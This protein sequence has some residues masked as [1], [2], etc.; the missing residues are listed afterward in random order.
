MSRANR[1]DR[2]NCG[3]SKKVVKREQPKA[4]SDSKRMN[5][6]NARVSRVRED[7]ER[8][9]QK[10]SANDISWYAK[11]PE[12]LKSAASIP[13]ASVLGRPLWGDGSRIPGIMTIGWEPTISGEGGIPINQ[14][15]DSM[16]SYIVH[17]N[18][19]NYNYTSPDLGLLMIAGSQVFAAIAAIVRAYGLV[20]Y[21]AERNEYYPDDCLV[22]MGF[23]PQDF[24]KN[25]GNTW[26]QLN[27]LIDQTRQ[28]WIP[29]VMPIFDRWIWL[30]SMIFT[31]AQGVQSQSYVF[32]QD[33]WYY[34]DETYSP[35]GGILLP[36]KDATGNAFN[37]CQNV[38]KIHNWID[39]VQ[40]MID[41]LVASEDRGIIFG[42]VLNAYGAE[43]IRAMSQIP[44]DYTAAPVY[45]MEALMQ[46]ENTFINT[47]T[48]NCIG[49]VDGRIVEGWTTIANGTTIDYNV[50]STVLNFHHPE[51]PSPEEIMIATRMQAFGYVFGA[52]YL[53]TT[54]KTFKF[55]NYHVR[56]AGIG[57]EIPNQMY[58]FTRS[59]LQNAKL[60]T[61]TR[62]HPVNFEENESITRLEDWLKL[63]AFD[64][65]PF[66]YRTNYP[67]IVDPSS[68]NYTGSGRLR[69]DPICA[70]GDFDNYTVLK[71]DELSKMHRVALFSLWGVPH[72]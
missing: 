2:R 65:H 24:R 18:S 31:D 1:S 30:N 56:I 15:F 16:Y 10:E 52:Y 4:D 55:G 3:T 40:Q 21:Y 44:S 53:D 72:I 26:F 7:I 51:Q 37:P 57:S 45:N 17:A 25:L 42:D 46:I 22:A 43:K 48:T 11:N 67:L 63:N 5:L 68:G 29:N 23:D 9:S 66:L 36:V 71:Y 59:P 13:F 34:Y 32:V 47:V 14:A 39:L 35:D 69:D 38:Y 50:G 58:I 33:K 64:W 60:P 62:I 27:N 41:N 8:D 70:Y 61:R 19:R 54:S 28:I 6:D 20:K 49:Q 12:L